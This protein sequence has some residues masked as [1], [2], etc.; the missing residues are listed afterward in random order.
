MVCNWYVQTNMSQQ[1]AIKIEKAC[2]KFDYPYRGFKIIPFTN[3]MPILKAKEPF[4]LIGSTTLMNNAYKSRK[5]KKG[6]FFNP[7][8][9][10]PTMYANYFGSD[11]LNY[12]M[13]VMKIKDVVNFYY[14]LPLKQEIFIRSNDDSKSISGG[15][16]LFEDLLEI[17]KNTSEHY[18]NGDLFTPESEVCI[19]TYKEINSEWRL[20][21]INGNVIASSQYSPQITSYVPEEVKEFGKEQIRKWQPQ[22]VFVLDVCSVNNEF[23]IVECNCMNGSGFYAADVEEIVRQISIYQCLKFTEYYAGI[24]YL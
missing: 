5:Y 9:F 11:Y 10:C 24:Q 4:V 22:D 16:C 2:E 19:A 18:I 17:C 12:D 21:V 20:F 14:Q 13:H 8:K 6:L 1:N 23:K 7:K 3:R 15:T